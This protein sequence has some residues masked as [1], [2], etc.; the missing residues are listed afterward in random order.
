MLNQ[1]L[2]A[3]PAAA[4][5]VLLASPQVRA[6]G[7]DSPDMGASSLGKAGA[8]AADPTTLMAIYYNPGALAEQPG[9]R[10]LLDGRGLFDHVRFQREITS[11]QLQYQPVSNTGAP[12]IAP[13][14]AVSY[15]FRT[16]IPFTIALGFNPPAAYSGDRYPDFF[17]IRS[18]LGSDAINNNTAALQA[19]QR[20]QLISQ[21][22]QGF[23]L[24]LSLAARFFSFLSIGAQLQVPL[25]HF[26]TT[27]ALSLNPK[28]FENAGYDAELALD[29]SNPLQV[30]GSFGATVELPAGL[31]LGAS[32]QLP[33]N[34]TAKGTMKITIPSWS[35]L[36][37]TASVAPGP[38]DL[39]IHL[40]LMARLGLRID[41][42][43]FELEL[44][45]VY[46]A[47]S[48]YNEITVN[49]HNITVFLTISPGNVSPIPVPVTHLATGM[50]DAGSV[51]LGG[52]LRPGVLEPRLSWLR[53]RAGLIYETSAV[54]LDYTSVMETN[55]DRFIPTVGLGATLG[56]IDI[57][58]AYAHAFQPER[59][60]TN[61]QVRMTSSLPSPPVVG[62]GTYSV[63]IDLLALS[64]AGHFG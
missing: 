55:W 38:A 18:K 11:P 47:W 5:L 49:P 44:D 2:L 10:F 54:P 42:P 25:Y 19:P 31:H 35:A 59:D 6:A 1:R 8:D 43:L 39:T 28:P 26:K 50:T 22:T 30:S 16:S 61:S 48:E 7:L 12:T 37:S 53:V 32:I 13:T 51:R 60:V 15:G 29:A 64:V 27:Q 52:E 33:T 14:I 57:D 46:E 58:L 56:P 24:D 9:F 20:Y 36:A 4:L 23:V 21:D 62:N 63:S 45:G 17:S 34:I 3:A 40:P 41:R